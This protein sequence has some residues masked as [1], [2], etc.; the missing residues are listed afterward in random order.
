MFTSTILKR[1]ELRQNSWMEWKPATVEAVKK[2]IGDDL[3]ECDDEQIAAFKR[4]AVEPY[5]A[6]IRRS[7]KMAKVI[8]VARRGD[9]VIYWEEVEEGFN[10]SPV[11]SDG[12][13][14]EQ[15]CSQD[16]LG[17]AL[18]AG[19]EGRSLGGKFGPATPIE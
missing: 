7:G 13:I 4:S 16:E 14:L 10:L 1:T 3:A 18:N 9:E 2:I 19:I 11:D 6:L 5:L 12:Q 8:V 17:F 15:W